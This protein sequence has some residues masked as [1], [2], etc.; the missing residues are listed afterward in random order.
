MRWITT[1][2]TTTAT[3]H[4]NNI[5][6]YCVY[7]Q[8]VHS[9]LILFMFAFLSVWHYAYNILLLLWAQLTTA[10]YTYDEDANAFVI[11]ISNGALYCVDPLFYCYYLL[12]NIR[13]Y[14]KITR[15]SR[16][17]YII[18]IILSVT[19]GKKGLQCHI[20]TN[21]RLFYLL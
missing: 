15:V 12:Y 11:T 20:W 8:C 19:L 9:M 5:I 3:V 21:L 6:L 2:T 13:Y 1:N 10:A 17:V 16:Y 7:I 18:S 4:N 14:S